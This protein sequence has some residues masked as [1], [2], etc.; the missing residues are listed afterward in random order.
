MNSMFQPFMLQE[1][2][3]GKY[4]EDSR[5]VEKK[6]KEDAITAILLKSSSIAVDFYCVDMEINYRMACN[7]LQPYLFLDRVRA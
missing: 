5:T 1:R 2:L 7:L 3:K 4:W 6:R